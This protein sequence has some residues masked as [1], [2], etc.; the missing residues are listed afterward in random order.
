LPKLSDFIL[1]AVIT[2][3]FLPEP[4]RISTRP[5]GMAGRVLILAG[6]TLNLGIDQLWQMKGCQVY[7]SLY[8]VSINF[9]LTRIQN[10]VDNDTLYV[11]IFV[12]LWIN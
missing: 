11:R 12:V 8:L 3:G 1:H 7:Q 2:A 4:A 6:K 10:N 9:A 5:N